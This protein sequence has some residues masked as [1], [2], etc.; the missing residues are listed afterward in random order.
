MSQTKLHTIFSHIQTAVS[1]LLEVD[2]F[3]V[4]MLDLD[5]GR[6]SFPYVWK[7]GEEL[8]ID[9]APW[10]ERELHDDRWGLDLV[11]K[12]CLDALTD[13]QKAYWPA[14]ERLPKS[15]LAVPTSIDAQ[16][17]LGLIVENWQTEGA[18]GAN[19]QRILETIAT[20]A[21]LSIRN[22][23]LVQGWQESEKRRRAAEKF[24]AVNMVAGEF[25]HSMNNIVGTVPVWIK[26]ARENL[27]PNDPRQAKVLKQ[28]D[29]ID[30]STRRLLQ[31]AQIVKE[32]TQQ[33]ARE[34]VDVNSVVNN[35][36]KRAI[37]SQPNAEERIDVKKELGRGLPKVEVERDSFVDTLTSIVKNGLESIPERGILTVSTKRTEKA[38]L[39]MVEIVIKDNGI[40][41]SQENLDHIFDPFF[42]TKDTGMGFGLWRDKTVIEELGGHIEVDSELQKGTIFKIRLPAS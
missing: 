8:P 38:G 9:Q 29:Q 24:M 6:L 11:M 18:F 21:A 1:E 31:K 30:L 20:Q 42:T 37:A 3:Y 14:N 5:R 15:W 41:I 27:D 33:R 25:A 36:L 7:D 35:A 22:A 19:H 28:L 13:W 17:R 26:L 12:D 16:T 39:P 4:A 2:R 34:P 23:R 40:G 32:A 10:I